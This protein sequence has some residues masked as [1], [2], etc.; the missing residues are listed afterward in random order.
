MHLQAGDAA[1]RAAGRELIQEVWEVVDQNYMDARGAGFDRQQWA[2]LRDKALSGSL[3]DQPS[4]H[5][6]VK[7]MLAKGMSDPYTRF[8]APQVGRCAPPPTTLGL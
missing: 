1:A 2:A 7:V 6:A 5:R 4:A 8:L 3:R